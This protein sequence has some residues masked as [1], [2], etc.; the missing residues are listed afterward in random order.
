MCG[1]SKNQYRCT[2]IK[3]K[4][5]RSRCFDRNRNLNRNKN[6]FIQNHLLNQVVAID[7]RA[8]PGLVQSPQ[9]WYLFKNRSTRFLSP[10]KQGF[11]KVFLKRNLYLSEVEANYI[12]KQLENY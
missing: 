5:D 2:L 9:T 1:N 12:Y 8:G 10:L 11:Y 6:L 4:S 3:K 7:L